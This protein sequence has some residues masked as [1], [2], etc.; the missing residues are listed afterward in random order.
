M[1]L[2]KLNASGAREAAATESSDG[3]DCS[4]HSISPAIVGNGSSGSSNMRAGNLL[5]PFRIPARELVPSKSCHR[6]WHML[7]QGLRQPR[8]L[9]RDEKR[10]RQRDAPSGHSRLAIALV[11]PAPKAFLVVDPQFK[12]PLSFARPQSHDRGRRERTHP[13]RCASSGL[14]SRVSTG[15]RSV[16]AYSTKVRASDGA[17]FFT[18]APMS[19]ALISCQLFMPSRVR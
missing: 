8:P 3:K 18:R 15:P 14:P 6:R 13:A 7:R 11:H 17:R 16:S 19:P 10:C 2:N 9:R 12:R 4:C 1:H 5:L